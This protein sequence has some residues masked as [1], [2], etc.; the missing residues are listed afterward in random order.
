MKTIKKSRLHL[1]A[2]ALPLHHNV[3]TQTSMQSNLH[4]CTT[5]R[6]QPVRALPLLPQKPAHRQ[7]VNAKKTFQDRGLAWALVAGQA[8]ATF[9][10]ASD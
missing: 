3:T 1:G 9:S 5:E 8:R 10:P 4:T 6:V 7:N 2:V